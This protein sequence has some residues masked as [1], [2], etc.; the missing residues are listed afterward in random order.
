MGQLV[1][2][3]TRDSKNGLKVGRSWDDGAGV[4][5]V[6]APAVEASTGMFGLGTGAGAVVA[7]TREM[8]AEWRSAFLGAA[9]ALS[10][11]FFGCPTRWCSRQGVL[12]R[13]TDETRFLQVSLEE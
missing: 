1:K 13:E 4:V 9:V 6:H 5:A 8:L 7:L 11:F 2:L 12:S 10:V 3:V